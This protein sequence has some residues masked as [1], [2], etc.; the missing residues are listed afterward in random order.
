MT[1]ERFVA[2]VKRWS[3][4]L[5]ILTVGGCSPRSLPGPDQQG[6]GM[7]VGAATGA[8]AGAVTG[9]QLTSAMGPGAVAGAGLGAVAGGIKGALRD[10]QQEAELQL[11]RDIQR[12]QDK[13]HVWSILRQHYDR[14]AGLFPSRDI[15]PAD[16]FFYGDERK[17]SRQGSALVEG[18]ARLNKERMPWSRLLV[19]CYVQ[20]ADPQSA[21]ARRLA[22]ARAREVATAMIRS[23]IEARRV[24]ARA[25]LI[26]KPIAK[27][28]LDVP[29]RYSQVVELIIKDR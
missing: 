14:R 6:G 3:I 27:D 18:L 26:D 9:F 8:A 11:A 25:V 1:S 28:P 13:V 4:V 15:L 7:V 12:E 20:S 16:L 29:D 22:E 17:L 19:A 24:E 23:G 10:S 2:G 21:Y 5:A